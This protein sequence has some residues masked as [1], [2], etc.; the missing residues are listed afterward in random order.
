VKKDSARKETDIRS[1]FPMNDQCKKYPKAMQILPTE[2]CESIRIGNIACCDGD[3]DGQTLFRVD[4]PFGAE[5]CRGIL[6][7]FKRCG[8]TIVAVAHEDNDCGPADGLPKMQDSVSVN[9]SH[10]A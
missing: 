5:F 8:R 2:D 4:R 1:A 3:E 10:P 9:R 7:E 6:S